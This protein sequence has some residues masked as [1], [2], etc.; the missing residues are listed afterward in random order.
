MDYN[1]KDNSR[2]VVNRRR[3]FRLLYPS[4][5]VFYT[6]TFSET[7]LNLFNIVC[8]DVYYYLE[9][10]IL[11]SIWISIAIHIFSSYIRIYEISKYKYPALTFISDCIEILLI[12]SL[13]LC[14]KNMIDNH[15]LGNYNYT[16]I[17]ILIEM[18]S[19]NQ[20]IWFI[21]LKLRDIKAVCRITAMSVFTLGLIIWEYFDASLLNHSLFVLIFTLMSIL[22]ICDKKNYGNNRNSK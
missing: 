17:Y 1:V 16:A 13:S 8:N 12:I 10:I 15:I 22:T 20:I 19:F 6:F 5:I 11:F 2:E 3:I 14:I 18:L 21:S 9:A 4:L 7:I